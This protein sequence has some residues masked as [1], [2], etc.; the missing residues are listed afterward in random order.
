MLLSTLTFVLMRHSPSGVLSE[1]APGQP[2]AP[3][4]EGGT[5]AV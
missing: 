5:T 3:E 2:L 4:P 1:M